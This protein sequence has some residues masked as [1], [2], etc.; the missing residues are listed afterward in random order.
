MGENIQLESHY[1]PT[2]Q[3]ESTKSDSFPIETFFNNSSTFE[4]SQDV[5]TFLLFEVPHGAAGGVIAI[6]L[7][8]YSMI[9]FDIYARFGSLPTRHV[10]DYHA[11]VTDYAESSVNTTS[12]NANKR[13]KMQLIIIYPHEG[14]WC[15]GLR[16]SSGHNLNVDNQKVTMSVSLQ[17]CPNHCSKHGT[18]QHKYEES[19]LTSFRFETLPQ[20]LH[21]SMISIFNTFSVVICMEFFIMQI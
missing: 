20:N 5:W 17:G 10:W 16:R 18:C 4:A 2:N 14:I 21:V 11:N 15:L 3:E 13:T 9:S 19:G 6:E 7:R 1:L 8:S 12:K